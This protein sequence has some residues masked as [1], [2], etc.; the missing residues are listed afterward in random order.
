MDPPDLLEIL[1]INYVVTNGEI[2][3]EANRFINGTVFVSDG[4][5]NDTASIVIHII[6]LNDNFPQVRTFLSVTYILWFCCCLE[7]T[8]KILSAADAT[9]SSDVN[10]CLIW[11]ANNILPF[12]SIF[13]FLE[14]D[15]SI[16]NYNAPFLKQYF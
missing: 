9:L 8:V 5:Q 12:F 7:Y 1:N 11:E 2:N 14:N 4:E 16:N 13:Q 10:M 3:A 15:R 6:D